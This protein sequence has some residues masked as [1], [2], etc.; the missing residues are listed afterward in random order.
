MEMNQN[1][2]SGMRALATTQ[3]RSR[4][5]HDRRDYSTYRR[6]LRNS[7]GSFAD[8]KFDMH[9]A[10]VVRPTDGMGDHTRDDRCHS[11]TKQS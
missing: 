1:F 9:T 8:L 10:N 2:I 5:P 3:R 6:H 7:H 11:E 4:K